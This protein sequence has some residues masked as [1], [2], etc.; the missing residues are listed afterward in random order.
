MIALRNLTFTKT[1]VKGFMATKRFGK[2]Y[3]IK[4]VNFPYKSKLS[5]VGLDPSQTN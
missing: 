2:T 5:E 1:Y 3:N 4:S